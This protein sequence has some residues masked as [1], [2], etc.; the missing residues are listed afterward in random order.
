MKGMLFKKSPESVKA[1]YLSNPIYDSDSAENR[2]LHEIRELIRYRNLVVQMVK[3]DITSR[4]KRS[5]LGVAWTLLDPLLTM[6]IMAIVYD[7]L[8]KRSIEDFPVFLLCGLIVWNYYSQSSS[9]AM[10]SLMYQGSLLGRVYFPKSVFG[11]T[12]VGTGLVNLLLSLIPLAIFVVLYGRPIT[13]ALAFIPLALLIITAFTL[14]VGLLVSLLGVYF[15][16]MVN[17]YSFIL[18][19]TMFLSGTF[20]YID[21]LPER[22]HKM[23]YLLPTY[24]MIRI[25]RDPVYE[26]VFPQWDSIIYA[27]TSA[28]VILIIGLWI[29]TKF[30]DGIAYRI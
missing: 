14:G 13:A 18:R 30:A 2:I 6:L 3:R 27:A 7:A 20:Y 28:L 29:F 22:L 25:F 15:G 9:Q 5:F 26:G 12:A 16:D 24:H 11:I 1:D 4:Y 8:F 23:I 19:L 10:S 21:S 17:I